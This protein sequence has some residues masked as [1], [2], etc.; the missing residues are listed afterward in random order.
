MPAPLAHHRAPTLSVSVALGMLSICMGLAASANAQSAATVSALFV[1]NRLSA[2]GALTLTVHYSNELG[3]LSP[4]RRSVM[5][6]P[7]RMGMSI[8][9][10]RSC[11]PAHLRAFG[12]KGCPRQSKIG[13]GHAIIEA[14]AGSQLIGESVVLGIFLG[15]PGN[16]LQPTFEVLGQGRTPLLERMVLDG[17]VIPGKAPYGET[18]VMNIPPIPTLALEPDATLPSLSL[19]I[20]TSVHRLAPT[21]NTVE[22]PDS[23][24]AGGFPF[25]GE[26]TYA[27]GSTS[28]SLATAPCPLKGSRH[29]L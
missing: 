17:T 3:L 27:D 11:S 5:R 2:K 4:L 28:S 10:L 20:G 6:L 1:P 26:F 9:A 24:P 16:D 14:R 7:A 22:V 12:D 8:P 13:S 29:A 18:I 21:A 19:T 15:P 23:C 25:A